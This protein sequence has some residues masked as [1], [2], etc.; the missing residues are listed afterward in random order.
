MSATMD[1]QKVSDFFG[2]CPIL[3][4]PGR[5]FPVDIRFLEDAVEYTG[6][7]IK[8]GSPYARRRTLN[9]PLSLH[10]PFLTISQLTINSIVT[11]PSWSGAKTHLTW[12]TT[13][14]A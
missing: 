1:S 13:M 8:E 2:G 6:W 9:H 11:S 12:M 4:V 7:T 5:T 10:I 3:N 14:K